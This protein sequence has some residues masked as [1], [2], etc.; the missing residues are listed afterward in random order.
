MWDNRGNKRNPKS[1]DYSCKDKDCRWTKN[2]KTGDWEASKYPTAM[3]ESDMTTG[4]KSEAHFDNFA[5][6]LEGD[7]KD[8]EIKRQ[9]YV[10]VAGAV[11]S[12]KAEFSD[13]PEAIADVV[14]KIADAI[15][16]R[17]ENQDG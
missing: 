16:K 12:G 11:L 2:K 15:E 8:K 13:D 1:P 3:W 17:E 10:K 14:C 5:K 4:Q 7:G 9:V 6:T